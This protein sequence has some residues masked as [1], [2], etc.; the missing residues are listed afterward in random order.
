MIKDPPEDFV[1]TWVIRWF[2]GFLRSKMWFQTKAKFHALAHIVIEITWIQKVC[3]ELF[4]EIVHPPLIFC[5]N[6]Y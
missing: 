2:H 1:F 3:T 5:D 6:E 4:I